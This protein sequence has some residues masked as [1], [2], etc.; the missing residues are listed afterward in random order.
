MSRQRELKLARGEMAQSGLN[1]AQVKC[2]AADHK[3]RRA[4]GEQN[5]FR[6]EYPGPRRGAVKN[7]Q[8]AIEVMGDKPVLVRFKERNVLHHHVDEQVRQRK[9]RGRCRFDVEA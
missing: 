3:N 7:Q 2:R 6:L 9:D 4:D 1:I 8:P 5:H